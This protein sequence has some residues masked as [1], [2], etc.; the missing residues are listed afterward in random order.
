MADKTA[1]QMKLEQMQKQGKAT[2]AHPDTI[3]HTGK[4]K[5]VRSNS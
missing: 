3:P 1:K 4:T 2:D 5:T